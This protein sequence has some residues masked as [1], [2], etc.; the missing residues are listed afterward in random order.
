MESAKGGARRLNADP[1]FRILSPKFAR[2]AII[3]K[4]KEPPKKGAL[5]LPKGGLMSAFLR[6]ET[7]EVRLFWC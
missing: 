1:S 5:A 4:A 7:S 6:G 2:F 3:T